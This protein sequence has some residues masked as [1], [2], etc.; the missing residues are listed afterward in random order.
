MCPKQTLTLFL[1]QTPLGNVCFKICDNLDLK[2]THTKNKR[3]Y[4]VIIII[5]MIGSI[6]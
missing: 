1:T 4:F 5:I 6:H 2:N 3:G